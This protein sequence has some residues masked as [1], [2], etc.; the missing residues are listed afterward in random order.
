M[1]DGRLKRKMEDGRWKMEFGVWSLK[2]NDC[3]SPTH[4]NGRNMMPF[5]VRIRT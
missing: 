4:T 3:Q 1:G 2:V 5:L